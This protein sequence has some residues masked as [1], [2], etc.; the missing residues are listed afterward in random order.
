MGSMS[1]VKLLGLVAIGIIIVIVA[2]VFFL[3]NGSNNPGQVTGVQFN[4]FGMTPYFDCNQG[5]VLLTTTGNIKFRLEQYSGNS[6]YNVELACGS[7]NNYSFSFTSYKNLTW[8]TSNILFT[9][10]SNSSR[11][12]PN[13]TLQNKKWV[14]VTNLPCYGEYGLLGSQPMGTVFLGRILIN[15]TLNPGTISASNKWNTN[16]AILVSTKVS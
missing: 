15:Y 1:S 11:G 14:N 7:E 9:S 3:F 2:A 5:S 12:L 6:L 4:C 8:D 16:F 10:L 13:S